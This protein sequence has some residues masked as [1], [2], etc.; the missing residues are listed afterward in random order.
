MTDAWERPDGGVDPEA[1]VADDHPDDGG[2]EPVDERHGDADA[3]AP[4]DERPADPLAPG[5]SIAAARD[6]DVVEPNEPA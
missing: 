2:D 5:E 1:Y 3:L 6:E 4:D